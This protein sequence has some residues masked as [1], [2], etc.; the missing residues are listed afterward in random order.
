MTVLMAV[1]VVGLQAGVNE[2]FDLS[3]EFVADCRMIAGTASQVLP[4]LLFAWQSPGSVGQPLDRAR[5]RQ[6]VC[7]VQMDADRQARCFDLGDSAKKR[8]SIGEQGGAGDDAIVDS[9]KYPPITI[10][11]AAKIVCIDN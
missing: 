2:S 11:A 3:C 4:Q 8:C 5:Q 6:A 10:W 9:L 1:Q 7:Q